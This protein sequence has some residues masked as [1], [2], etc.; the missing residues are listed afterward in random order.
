VVLGLCVGWAQGL[1]ALGRRRLCWK[2]V[3]Y[4]TTTKRW[5]WVEKE[6]GLG[7]GSFA[8]WLLVF[9]LFG[10]SKCVVWAQVD[11]AFV[12]GRT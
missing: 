12:S 11:L 2:F 7:W 3:D 9:A 5:V 1:F 10:H 6:R 4:S 8:R